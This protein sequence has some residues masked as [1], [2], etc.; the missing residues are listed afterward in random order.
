MSGGGQIVKHHLRILFRK[1]IPDLTKGPSKDA[2]SMTQTQQSREERLAAKL[3][4]NLRRRKV[5]ARAIT[6]TGDSAPSSESGDKNDSENESGGLPK[7]APE[8]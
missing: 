1:A 4:E 3:R 6:V 8:S 7:P 2:P 5:Q